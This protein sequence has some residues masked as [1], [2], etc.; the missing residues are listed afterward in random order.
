MAGDH[1]SPISDTTVLSA[2]ASDCQ[3]MAHVSTQAPY[4]TMMSIL[5]IIFGTVPIGRDAWPNIIGILLGAVAIALIVFGLCV[6]I[7]S[8]TGRFDI[9]TT[10]WIKYK[11]E[12][13]DLS[14]LRDD[15]ITSFSGSSHSGPAIND[16]ETEGMAQPD[17]ISDE[18]VHDV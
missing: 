2:L 5:A 9:C 13:C 12:D 7:K 17:K 14:Q 10:L 1:V 15:T 4:A 3:L 8:P 6:P 11:G 18:E 16:E